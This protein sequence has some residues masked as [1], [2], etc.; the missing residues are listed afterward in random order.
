VDWRKHVGD[1]VRRLRLPRGLSQEKL[2]GDAVIDISCLREI[3]WA[4]RN[5]R[6]GVAV[7]LAAAFGVEPPN[8][9]APIIAQEER[10]RRSDGN[11][12]VP[13]VG[14]R[15]MPSAS[16]AP[17]RGLIE[18]PAPGGPLLLIRRAET[19]VLFSGSNLLER[20]ALWGHRRSRSVPVVFP[21]PAARQPG[22]G[23]PSITPFCGQP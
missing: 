20:A 16:P 14:R 3:E 4:S 7:Q 9:L 21:S 19:P 11:T 17:G 1:N 18:T 2:A 5:P 8:L 22:R 6:L 23:Y 12:R 13:V 15:T 10:G